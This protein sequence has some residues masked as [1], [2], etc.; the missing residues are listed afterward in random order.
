M[1]IANSIHFDL[2]SNKMIQN[3][4]NFENRRIYV[5]ASIQNDK[6][7]NGKIASINNFNPRTL[8]VRS[9]FCV[10]FSAHLVF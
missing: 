9:I 1:F 10:V 3:N 7:K 8:L 4:F 5:P 2:I 6:R